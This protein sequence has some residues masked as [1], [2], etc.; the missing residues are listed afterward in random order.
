MKFV[1]ILQG[2]WLG[3]PL[4]PAIIH[5]PVGGWLV[6]CALDVIAHFRTDSAWMPE[7]ALWATGLGLAGALLAIAPGFA[8]WSAIKPE[9]PAWKLALYHML[10]N[11][12]GTATWATNFVLRLHARDAAVSQPTTA[13]LWTSIIGTVVIFISAYLG[14]LIVFDQGIGVARESKKKWREIAIRGGAKVPEE[15]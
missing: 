8:D 1:E 2:K 6:A 12:A 13:I 10:L 3:H 14:S 11:V 7:A 9:K 15:K 5:V 4:H